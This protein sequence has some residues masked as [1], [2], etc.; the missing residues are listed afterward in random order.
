MTCCCFLCEMLRKTKVR[1]LV[2]KQSIQLPGERG[3][4]HSKQTKPAG[5]GSGSRWWINDQHLQVGKECWFLFRSDWLSPP[6]LTGSYWSDALAAMT[7]GQGDRRIRGKSD[8]ATL[9]STPKWNLLSGFC[10]F[11]FSFQRGLR[12]LSSS[13]MLLNLNSVCFVI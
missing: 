10:L 9:Q 7:E 1:C 8:P 2:L 6:F 13:D 11:Y 12:F 5:G 4:L 3:L